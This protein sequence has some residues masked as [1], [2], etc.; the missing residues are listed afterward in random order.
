M[1][2]VGIIFLTLVYTTAFAQDSVIDSLEAVLKTLPEETSKVDTQCALALAYY[3]SNANKTLEYGQKAKELSQKL[4][5]K[6]GILESLKMIGIGH[7]IK[8]NIEESLANYQE[9]LDLAI[10]LKEYRHEATLYNN[11]AVV[12]NDQGE[13]YIA[14]NLFFEG[15]KVL[16][17]SEIKELIPSFIQ[18]IGDTYKDL[19]DYENAIRYTEKAIS[20]FRELNNE[21]GLAVCINNLG[22]IYTIQGKYERA[23]SNLMESRNLF[24]KYDNTR[25]ESITT[26]NIG[27][28]YLKTGRLEAAKSELL[29]AMRL[30]MQLD[31][32]HGL[33]HT[34]NQLGQLEFENGNKTKALDYF[35]EA[36]DIVN[37]IGLK[38]IQRDVLASLARYYKNE[39][40]YK[41]AL[42][43][44]E[45]H[46]QLRDSLFNIDRNRQVVELQTLYESEKKERENIQ[47][48][49]EQLKKDEL[50][51]Q[52]LSRQ[53]M[54]I[55][56]LIVTT[57]FVVVLIY[58]IIQSRKANNKLK[59]LNKVVVERNE[60]IQA[61]SEELNEAYEEIKTIN[62]NL[63]QTVLSRTEKLNKSNAELSEF[64]YRAS[65]DLKGPIMTLQGLAYLGSRDGEKTYEDIIERVNKT[66]DEMNSTLN[67]LLHV[68]VVR[69]SDLANQK[70]DFDEIVKKVVKPKARLI[71]DRGISIKTTIQVDNTFDSDPDL[72]GIIFENLISNGIQ[73][74]DPNKDEKRVEVTITGRQDSVLVHVCDNGVGIEG[75]QLEKIFE[76]FYRGNIRSHGN[77][78]G[79]YI[80]KVAVESLK[81]KIEINSE[82]GEGT[83]VKMVFPRIP[84]V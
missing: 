60:E 17:E 64:L 8:G 26:R 83:D 18:N 32:Q 3:N 15:L 40:D 4:D 2:I 70:I 25:G 28:I 59:M 57:V 49:E 82:V 73:Y 23:L 69:K 61:Q 45:S 24:I 76:M 84:S 55:A 80:T 12:H 51:M 13:Y 6:K 11:M 66:A 74:C 29:K 30:F 72:L 77:G 58:F 39:G 27:D 78:L 5:Y 20:L 9:A 65:H 62:A 44:Y 41:K 21:T 16:E 42:K 47:L 38:D 63:E 22:E 33:A 14:L 56:F 48:K 71:S 46:L 35:N 75:D 67:N 10:T 52:Q 7:W 53:R 36:Y 1:R 37:D 54:L 79:L 68:N 81:G 19:E 43:Y 31:N 50:L 34:L